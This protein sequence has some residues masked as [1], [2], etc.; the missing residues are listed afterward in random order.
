LGDDAI[1]R[2]HEM[3]ADIH[4]NHP[5]LLTLPFDAV[6]PEAR[7]EFID[8][9]SCAVTSVNVVTTDGPGGRYGITV[10]AMC[11]VSADPPLLL[12]CVNRKSPLVDAVA[13]NEAFAVNLLR[14]DQKLVA[15]V[16]AGRARDVAP[17]DFGCAAWESS[18]LGSPLLVGAVARFDCRLAGSLDAGT[19]RVL[20]GQVEGTSGDPGAALLYARRAFGEARALPG[21][22]RGLD[23]RELL[24]PIW[25]EPADEEDVE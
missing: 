9:M 14:A 3:P 21:Y 4:Q 23:E 17:Y 20:L 24:V 6:E 7:E 18:P 10:S 19:H 12:V 1:H 25:D 13:R 2:G 15:E 16:F 5:I 22:H 8:G 11:S